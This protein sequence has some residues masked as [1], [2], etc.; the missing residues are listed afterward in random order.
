MPVAIPIIAGA[1]VGAGGAIA[2]GIIAKDAA[3]AAAEREQQTAQ[4][5]TEDILKSSQMAGAQRQADISAQLAQNYGTY[6]TQGAQGL[7][8]L[9]GQYGQIAAG[10][11]PNPA[12]AQLALQTGK[13]IQQQ[14][15]LQAGQRGAGANVGLIARQ[16]GQQGA[17]LQQDAIGQAA[18]L[19]AQQ[20]LAGLGAQAGIAGSQVSQALAA[21]NAA[22]QAAQYQAALATQAIQGPGSEALKGQIEAENAAQ[23]YQQETVKG[24]TQGLSS[25]AT[26]LASPTTP[27]ATVSPSTQKNIFG[28]TPAASLSSDLYKAQG[29]LI[30]NENGPQSSI[31]KY[32]FKSK[33]AKGG[34]VVP[35]LV[36]PGERYLSPSEVKKVTSGKKSASQAGEKIPGIPV[37]PGSVDSYH[38]DTVHK[39]LKEGGIVLP[40]SVTQAK[41]KEKAAREFIVKTLR[42]KQAKKQS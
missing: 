11:G 16:I 25:L 12:L 33:M 19:Q 2:Q 38:N 20:Q 6:G 17:G 37:I 41:D 13:N 3:K 26:T 15:A 35:A 28:V 30:E 21:Q 42:E 27:L 40:R 4:N 29:G 36:S 1:A 8:D 7:A 10:Q 18:V 32:F 23:G 9:Y 34:E 31:G 14:A 22:N 5:I 24:A 39:T